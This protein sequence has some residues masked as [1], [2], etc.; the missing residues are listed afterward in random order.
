MSS[1]N[2]VSSYLA[3]NSAGSASDTANNPT[4]VL[5]QADFLK[6][7]VAQ[8]QNQ[9]P[10]NPQ[11][12]T[13]MA[14]QMAQFSAL[15]A[16]TA[17]SSSLSMIQANG[18]V[19]NTVTLQVDTNGTTTSGVVQGVVMQSGTPEIMVNGTLY[20]LGQVLQVQPTVASTSNTSSSS[21]SQN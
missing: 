2:S 10:M 7:L 18:L 5:N 6:L 21:T 15:T 4:S 1:V 9:D 20:K 12:N 14:A 13:D 19:G 11:S 3:S 16:S 8:M 17:S